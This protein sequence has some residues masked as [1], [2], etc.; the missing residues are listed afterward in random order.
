[1]VGSQT[2]VRKI[3]F[4]YIVFS[5]SEVGYASYGG[6]ISETS[7]TGTGIKN[8]RNGINMPN[9][10]LQGLTKLNS[11]FSVGITSNIDSDF[12]YSYSVTGAPL[13]FSFSY[14]MIGTTLQAICST[15]PENYAYDSQCVN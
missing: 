11:G 15:C 4:S 14:V 2:N 12:V 10:P 13:T 3:W 8:F 5:P 9:Y 1:M 7:F 6:I